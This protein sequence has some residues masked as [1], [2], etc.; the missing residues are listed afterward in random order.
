M[1]EVVAI[2]YVV[3][4]S[5]ALASEWGQ[6]LA[7]YI[8][9]LLHRLGELHA[10]PHFRLGVVTYGPAETRPSPLLG[11]HFFAQPQVII[12]ELREEP[13]RLGLGLTSSGGSTG[14]A[15]LEGLVAA[16]E[17]FDVLKDSIEV[18]T[19]HIIHVAATPPDGSERPVWNLASNLDDVSWE[20]LPLELRKRNINYSSILLNPVPRFSELSV[21]Q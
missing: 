19:S 11:K 3:D 2:A 1:V 17:L 12:K 5:L 10:N 8:L 15:A 21:S 4:A 6:A 9:P 16:L 18:M 20:T 13:E 7:E 14:M